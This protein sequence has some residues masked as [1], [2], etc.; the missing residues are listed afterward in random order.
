MTIAIRSCS[1]VSQ[2]RGL[3]CSFEAR[4][5]SSPS[6][7]CPRSPRLGPWIRPCR[8]D[9]V[10]VRICGL[11]IAWVQGVAATPGCWSE[12]SCSSKTSAGVFQSGLLLQRPRYRPLT[13]TLPPPFRSGSQSNGHFRNFDKF[14]SLVQKSLFPLRDTNAQMVS[15]QRI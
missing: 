13:G 8:Y 9:P 15:L 2:R 7:R 1:R 10:R 3:G 6:R 5:R 11:E 12:R 14:T 4:K